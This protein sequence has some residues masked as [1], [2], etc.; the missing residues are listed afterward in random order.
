[1]SPATADANSSFVLAV[2]D[3]VAIFVL[4]SSFARCLRVVWGRD[5]DRAT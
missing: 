5:A 1:M 4:L 3:R 2:L